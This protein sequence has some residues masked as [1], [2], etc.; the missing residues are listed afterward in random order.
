MKETMDYAPALN[1]MEPPEGLVS[2]VLDRGELQHEV[3]MYKAGWEYEPLEDR[4]VPVAE[5]ACS[6]CG[7]TF[8][9]RKIDAGACCNSYA[10]APF[11]WWNEVTGEAVISGSHSTCPY[12]NTAAE[13][14]HVGAVPRGVDQYAFV[15][16]VRRTPGGT[17]GP[18]RL[19]LVDWQVE[20]HIDKRGQTCFHTRPWTAWVVEEKK[21]VRLVGYTKCLSSLSRH[22]LKQRKTFLDDYGQADLV[23]PWDAGILTG[24]TAENCKLDLF[25]AQGGTYLV[26]Y[27]ALWRK[28]PA[29]ENLVT[30]GMGRLVDALISEE[31][32]TNSYERSR[33]VPKLPAVNWK[34]AK[35]HRML[36]LSRAEVRAWAGTLK[37]RDLGLISWARGAGLAVDL[38][39]DLEKLRYL[40]K[41]DAAEL[42]KEA[43]ERRFWRAA[44][45]LIGSGKHWWE[46]RDY[47][48]MAAALEMDLDNDQVRYPKDLK[49]AHDRCV[50]RYNR[51]K[52]QLVQAGF[53]KRMRELE[54]F[55]W[56]R[57]GILIRPCASQTELRQEGKILSHCVA[58]YAEDHAKGRTAILFIRR[59]SE[60]DKPWYTLELNERDLTVRQNRGKYN[61]ART[62][63]V[64]AFEEAWL[65]HIRG[66]FGKKKQRAGRPA[67]QQKGANAA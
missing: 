60:P 24:T 67:K 13:V 34:E 5:V 10:P 58:Q 66:A 39:R 20:R 32:K 55:A 1:A 6:G 21:V 64:K 27:L 12:C 4:N 25:L 49:A 38:D 46:L 26:G 59:A 22:E 56:E 30:S 19:A 43:G 52:D 53:D 29:V 14:K 17:G 7:R 65:E 40:G 3:L 18:D 33:G 47:W 8:H 62:E 50:E 57:D 37:P 28:R 36:G 16:E 44:R 51:Q 2:W 54:K 63:E 45:Y 23:W 61:C 31:D 48:S 41:S 35:P 42:L 9:A 11:G 15:T